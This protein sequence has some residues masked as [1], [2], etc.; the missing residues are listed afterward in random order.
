M[1]GFSRRYKLV[2][3][4][5][6]F[7]QMESNKKSILAQ[8][9]NTKIAKNSIKKRPKYIKFGAFIFA[10]TMVSIFQKTTTCRGFLQDFA[11]SN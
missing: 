3:A 9:V 1:I 2:H 6:N 8:S 5:N 7:L 4:K 11:I 10:I